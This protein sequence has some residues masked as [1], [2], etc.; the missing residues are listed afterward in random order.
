LKI[1]ISDVFLFIKPK[2]YALW[3]DEV[4]IEAFIN[5]NLASLDKFE[6]YL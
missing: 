2:D 5:K 3:K 4:E 1:E 6:A